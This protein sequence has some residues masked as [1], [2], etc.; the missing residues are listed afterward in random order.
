MTQEGT[1]TE[2]QNSQDFLQTLVT[3]I[4]ERVRLA[5]DFYADWCAPCKKISPIFETLAAS[6]TP[7]R[8]IRVNV[9]KCKEVKQRLEIQV[10]PTFYFYF[11]GKIVGKVFGANEN[12]LREEFE[13]FSSSS[14]ETLLS[15]VEQKEKEENRVEGNLDWMIDGDQLEEM[16]FEPE[17]SGGV[18]IFSEIVGD[19]E[20]VVRTDCDEQFLINMRFKKTVMLKGLRILAPE[21]SGPKVVK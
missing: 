2:I 15:M 12:A 3:S 17:C 8:C 6:H 13:N 21:D 16:N 10:L 14:D 5:V 18:G 7:I 9:D 4:T 19:E 1:V 20:E 11:Q